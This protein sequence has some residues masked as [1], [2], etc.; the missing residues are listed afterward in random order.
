VYSRIFESSPQA[1]IQK[2]FH[3]HRKTSSLLAEGNPTSFDEHPVDSRR[4]LKFC[5]PKKHVGGITAANG[6][7]ALFRLYFRGPGW[8]LA[9]TQN[10]QDPGGHLQ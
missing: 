6:L 5:N 4:R 9:F 8:Q 7:R 3:R 2:Y 1:K 10:F